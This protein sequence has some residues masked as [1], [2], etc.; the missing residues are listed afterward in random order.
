M[1]NE[2]NGL[3]GSMINKVQESFPSVFTKEDVATLINELAVQINSIPEPEVKPAKLT[4]DQITSVAYEIVHELEGCGMDLIEDYD[5]HMSYREVELDSVEYST[6]E[7]KMAIERV[8]ETFWYP[9]EQEV[10]DPE[11]KHPLQVVD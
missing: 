4:Q 5:L 2:I 1:K 11:Y 6:R 9:E 7:M 3:L 8:L 10:V